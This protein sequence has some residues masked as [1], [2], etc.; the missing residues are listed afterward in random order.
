MPQHA[1]IFLILGFCLAPSTFAAEDSKN[2]VDRVFDQSSLHVFHLAN[3]KISLDCRDFLRASARPSAPTQTKELLSTDEK[4]GVLAPNLIKPTPEILLQSIIQAEDWAL[5]NFRPPLNYHA[6]QTHSWID[7]L[8][9]CRIAAVGIEDYENVTNLCR[10][11]IWLHLIDDLKETAKISIEDFL[12]RFKGAF[13][14]DEAFPST[15]LLFF[16]ERNQIL[17]VL[18]Q[19]LFDIYQS[20]PR[21]DLKLRRNLFYFGLKKMLAGDKLFQSNSVVRFQHQIELSAKFR[22]SSKRDLTIKDLIE[23][24]DPLFVAFT[25]NSLFESIEIFQEKAPDFHVIQIQNLVYGP[26]VNFHDLDEEVKKEGRSTESLPTLQ[27]VESSYHQILSVVIQL[28]IDEQ[29]L[30]WSRFPWILESFAGVLPKD[31]RLFFSN[32]LKQLNTTEVLPNW[33]ETEINRLHQKLVD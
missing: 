15:D 14:E 10:S 32:F 12:S 1:I 24:L 20:L 23:S 13:M 16:N 30:I 26:I 8:R 27:L 6:S 5:K 7:T 3:Q 9:Q 28:P 21:N 22:S 4:K 31:V 18:S 25:V 2:H 17:Q 11:I 19:S 29:R 33:T